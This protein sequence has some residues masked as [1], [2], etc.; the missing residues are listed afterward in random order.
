MESMRYFRFGLVI[1]ISLILGC[2]GYGRVRYL[3]R[4]GETA[5]VEQLVEVFDDFNV[6]Y[7]GY[8]VDNPSGI[9]FDPKNDD[10]TLAP[11]DRWIKIESRDTASEVVSWIR[12]QDLPGYFPA[13]YG[14][15]GPDGRLFGYMY[16]VW[17]SRTFTKVI[18]ENTLFVYDL[19]DP[20]HYYGPDDNLIGS[21]I[22]FRF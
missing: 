19:P 3:P 22:G 2:S 16:S 8:A 1:A 15:Y 20:P 13:L 6:Y 7:A 14:I 12:I 18:D 11:S 10:K 5:T 17:F 9:L 21:G 4:G